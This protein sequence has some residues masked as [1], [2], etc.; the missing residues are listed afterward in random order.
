MSEIRVR[1]APSPSGYFHVGT[2]RTAIFNY[3][4][5]RAKGG[6][7]ILRIE[8]TDV[9]RSS[10]EMV[11]VILYGLQ[12][13]DV[14]WDEGPYHQSR[15][16]DLYPPFAEELLL[17][18]RAYRCFCKPEELAA[19]R[20]EAQKNKQTYQYDR[21]CR[22]LSEEE[23]DANL[24]QGKAFTVRLKL[25]VEGQASFHDEVLGE[26]NKA[27]EDL[28]DFIIVRSD[29]RPVYNFAVVVD[30]ILMK[31]THV[32]RGNDHVANT[33]KQ[34]EIYDALGKKR[35][36]Y[37]H[38]PLLLRPDRSKVSKRKGDKSVTE[39]R[40]DGIMPDALFNYLALLGWSPKDDREIM[41][42][43]EIIRV[44]DFKGIN[45]TNAIFDPV[46][47]TWMNSQ[48]IMKTDNHTLVQL[49]T[50]FIIEADLAT[51][52][53]IETRWQWM[54]RVVEVLK[55]RC[56]TLKDFAEN[57]SYFFRA[58]FEYDPK[59]VQKRFTAEGLGDQLDEVR[60]EMKKHFEIK[61]DTAEK[62]VRQKA[63]EFGIKPAALI[64][65]IRLALTGV[66]GGPGLF[67]IIE[68]LGQ[69]EVDR[70]LSRAI[71]FIR[72]LE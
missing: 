16:Y 66:T 4:F 7:F 46:K 28:D 49:I 15:R 56:T 14:A 29:G 11:D 67:D 35:P 62:I 52:Y 36:V 23:I 27:Y 51:K 26:M 38:L 31:V 43:D 68:I 25:P 10:Q 72:N 53:W 30:D 57:G 18:K 32:I 61:K 54:L 34:N 6:K 17:S 58:D 37:A 8:D 13:L 63:E 22:N 20:E 44:F 40:D 21:T 3:L 64:H 59:G 69:P 70:R 42:R 24:N 1:I 47:L 60:E 45:P 33:F 71:E 39:Y 55:E 12:W 50:P 65:P 9:E 41:S 5:A 48:Y 2:A 19:K